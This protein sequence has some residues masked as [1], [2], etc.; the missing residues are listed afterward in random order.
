MIVIT[1]TT[2]AT[3]SRS[4]SAAATTTTTTTTTSTNL[5]RNT[6]VRALVAM[7]TADG[8]CSGGG[9]DNAGSQTGLHPSS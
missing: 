5:G 3:T 4:T 2:A 9:D 8:D 6:I 7:I 1:T